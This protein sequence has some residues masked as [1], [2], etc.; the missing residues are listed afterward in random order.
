MQATDTGIPAGLPAGWQPG[1][2]LLACLDN[3][4]D[5]VFTSALVPPIREAFPG[6]RIVV[7]CKAYAADIVPFMPGVDDAIASDPF[8]D[9]SPGRGKGS[10]TDFLTAWRSVR[11]GRFDLAVIT[12]RHWRVAA[13]VSVARVPVRIGYDKRHT[14]FW[15]THRVADADREKPVVAELARLLDP[16]G[17]RDR[18]RTYAMKAA[19][20]SED[21]AA[22]RARLG[23]RSVVAL[24][25][26]ASRRDRCVEFAR[27]RS[28]AASLETHGLRP[29]WVGSPRELAAFRAEGGVPASSLFGDQVGGRTLADLARLLSCVALY[30]GHDSGPLHIAAALGVPSVGIFAPGQPRRTFPQGP[31]PWRMVAAD[32][33]DGVTAGDMISAAL[34][35]RPA[36]A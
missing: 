36:G 9:K 19:E 14:G 15:L 29:L 27:W 35:L 25:P 33:P 21:S 24:H 26:F 18:V 30:I 6:S 2:I 11:R 7:W 32:S 13:S 31:G 4:G 10:F 12:S 22:I 16:L 28:V 17:L 5:L 23:S 20:S 8:W 34:A 3:V 1:R